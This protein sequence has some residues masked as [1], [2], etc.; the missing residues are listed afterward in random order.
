MRWVTWENVGVD[1]MACAW[2]IKRWIDSEAEFSFI[3]VAQK[4]LPEDAEP[5]DI[6]GVRFSH[7]RGHCSFHTMLREFNIK[8]PILEQIAKIV[9][10]ADTIQ[11][12]FLEPVA[13]GLDFICDGIRLISVDDMTALERGSLVFEA[14]YAQL[15][16]SENV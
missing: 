5:F 14:L 11:D 9:D 7:R 12:A 3:P 10:E 16:A 15:L 2:L 4:P 8:D 6:P 1:R 13:P